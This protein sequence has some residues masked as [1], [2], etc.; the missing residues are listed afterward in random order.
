M[1]SDDLQMTA[2]NARAAERLADF[3]RLYEQHAAFVWRTLRG[4]GVSRDDIEDVAQ[5]VFTTV[6]RKLGSFEGRSSLR[7]WLCGI[8]VGVARNHTRKRSRREGAGAPLPQAS[9]TPAENAE[10]L[11]LVSKCLS[12]LSEELRL[13][14]ILAELEQLTAPE[15]AE[16][17]TI[18]VNTV[19]SRLRL[20]REKFEESVVRHGGPRS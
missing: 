17:L 7:T 11:D 5:E 16:V 20:A 14:F 19:Y 4:L 18:N 12:E 3:D 6:F 8:A 15:I 1:R 2:A 10:T 9:A 13:V